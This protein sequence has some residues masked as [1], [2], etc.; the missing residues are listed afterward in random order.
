G[1]DILYA[2]AGATNVVDGGA[3]NDQLVGGWGNEQYHWGRGGG[4]DVIRE[5][6][7]GGFDTLHIGAEVSAD[8]I[9]LQRA[10]N[11]LVLSIV[12]TSDSLTLADWYANDQ[13]RVEAVVLSSE[14]S[15]QT[16][17]V[18]ALVAAMA[19]FAPPAAGVSHLPESYQSVLMPVI[20]VGWQ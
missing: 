6:S 19:S 3:G 5:V 20:A 1:D 4:N 14:L 17:Q 8:Q 9:W 12:G 13:A 16:A 18:D 7:G 11:D 10:S 2:N 15:L